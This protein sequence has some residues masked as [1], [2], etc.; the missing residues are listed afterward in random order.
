MKTGMFFPLSSTECT[1]R[2]LAELDQTFDISRVLHKRINREH[3][4]VAQGTKR[5]KPPLIHANFSTTE[6]ILEVT[7]S[8]QPEILELPGALF[9]F[10]IYRQ[11]QN[12]RIQAVAHIITR[13]TVNQSSPSQYHTQINKI[14]STEYDLLADQ[15]LAQP[16]IRPFKFGG[17]KYSYS[18]TDGVIN[19]S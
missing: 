14:S 10:F 5:L 8:D 3:Y 7:G 16:F 19:D 15:S 1:S 13:S 11:R 2:H 12:K 17:A 18:I 6:A 9:D 4:V